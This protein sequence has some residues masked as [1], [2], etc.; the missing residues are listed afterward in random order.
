MNLDNEHERNGRACI[1]IY[2]SRMTQRA[3][4]VCLKHCTM[5]QLQKQM[6][7]YC[8]I[9]KCA[10]KIKQTGL[11]VQVRSL[12]HQNCRIHIPKSTG[13]EQHTVK[14]IT[15]TTARTLQHPSKAYRYSLTDVVGGSLES[16]GHEIFITAVHLDTHQT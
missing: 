4:L 7:F 6:Y 15:V 11:L 8:S 1:S 5:I 3:P 10:F 16:T 2:N 14:C 13:V 12:L 9:F